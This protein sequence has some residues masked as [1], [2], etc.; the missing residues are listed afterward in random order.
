MVFFLPDMLTPKD[1]VGSVIRHITI[2]NGAQQLW[3]LEGSIW[4]WKRAIQ[5][6]VRENDKHDIFDI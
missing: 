1:E 6:L 4:E 3:I 5:C 2:S